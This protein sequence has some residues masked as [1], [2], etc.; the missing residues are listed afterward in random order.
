MGY[1]SDVILAVAIKHI[2]RKELVV[3]LPLLAEF[4]T[5]L[6]E[7]VKANEY[8]NDGDFWVFEWEYVKWY[9]SYSDIGE[10]TKWMNNLTDESYHFLRV[11]EDAGDVEEL[12][13]LDSG[14][15]IRSI[16]ER[17]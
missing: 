8:R 3:G 17:H 15:Y 5:L 13:S 14:Y 9:E 16:I 7:A 11:G 10:V 12:G 6:V 1:R 2:P 4:P